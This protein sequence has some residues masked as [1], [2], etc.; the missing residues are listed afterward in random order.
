MAHAW[1]NA[2]V[3]RP[4]ANSGT[5]VVIAL[6]YLV[7]SQQLNAQIHERHKVSS[8]DCLDDLGDAIPPG[9]YERVGSSLCRT[10]HA[11][12][13]L[14]HVAS[15]GS[16]RIYELDTLL[17]LLHLQRSATAA[18]GRG[19]RCKANEGCD[20]QEGECPRDELVHCDATSTATGLQVCLS[21]R[22]KQHHD[23]RN[24]RSRP[25]CSANGFSLLSVC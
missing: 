15:T 23:P 18:R 8:R 11:R 4:P 9:D 25:I 2:K 3:A 16:R 6:V 10:A 22:A 13:L 19:R 5:N 21:Q 24:P 14:D 12:L 1:T 20:T 7:G 17:R